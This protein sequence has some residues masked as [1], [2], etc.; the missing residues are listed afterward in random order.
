MLCR[1]NHPI[2]WKQDNSL[3]RLLFVCIRKSLRRWGPG[4]N[5]PIET[6][7]STRAEL[8]LPERTQKDRW[9]DCSLC[10]WIQGKHKTAQSLVH[11]K[12]V[13]QEKVSVNMTWMLC[14]SVTCVS[15]R[16][17]LKLAC[18]SEM[19]AVKRWACGEREG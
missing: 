12:V 18:W 19:M 8:H 17:T 7:R 11:V 6:Q 3:G 2:L 4:R 10:I 9:E 1:K 14:S 5:A 16:E 13:L 15:V